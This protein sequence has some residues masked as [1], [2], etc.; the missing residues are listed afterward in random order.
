MKSLKFPDWF[1]SLPSGKLSICLV[2]RGIK[3]ELERIFQVGGIP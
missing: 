2:W 3:F 1:K